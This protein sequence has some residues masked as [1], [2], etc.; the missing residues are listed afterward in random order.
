[1][2]WLRAAS[3]WKKTQLNN[4]ETEITRL[5][6]VETELTTSKETIVALN[7]NIA[8]SNGSVN[9]LTAAALISD[10][11]IKELEAEVIVLGKKPSSITGS[12]LTTVKDETAEGEK[13]AVYLDDNSPENVWADKQM[14]KRKKTA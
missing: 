6:G 12:S 2:K 9:S 1:M 11:R 14:R 5:N 3:Y 10:A 7:A 8:A 13:V 4:I